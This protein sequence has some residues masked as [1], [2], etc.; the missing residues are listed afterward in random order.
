MLTKLSRILSSIVTLIL[1]IVIFN[2]FNATDQETLLF[3]ATLIFVHYS[4]SAVILCSL[5]CLLIL[6]V[7]WLGIHIYLQQ[8]QRYISHKATKQPILEGFIDIIIKAI[9]RPL[10]PLYIIEESSKF[11]PVIAI[12]FIIPPFLGSN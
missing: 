10:C 6:P 9:L 11:K 1:Y 5:L 12:G 3:I 7:Y 8:D 4:I 2:Y